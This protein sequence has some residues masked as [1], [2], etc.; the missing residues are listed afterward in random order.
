VQIRGARFLPSPVAGPG[1]AGTETH[2]AQIAIG[3]AVETSWAIPKPSKSA[4]T[5]S[6][7][8]AASARQY[9]G[10]DLTHAKQVVSSTSGHSG[11]HQ[12]GLS[13]SRSLLVIKII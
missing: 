11:D 1:Q 9:Q 2:T 4:G 7:G 10:T 13:I 6:A 3:H 8:H 5:P 12:A